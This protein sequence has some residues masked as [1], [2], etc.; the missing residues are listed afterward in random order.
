[1]PE[2]MD[3]TCSSFSLQLVELKLERERVISNQIEKLLFEVDRECF[4]VVLSSNNASELL[5]LAQTEC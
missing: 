3:L 2:N 5:G 1:M 4:Q